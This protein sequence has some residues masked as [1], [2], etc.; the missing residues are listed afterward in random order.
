MAVDTIAPAMVSAFTRRAVLQTGIAMAPLSGAM[1]LGSDIIDLRGALPRNGTLEYRDPSKINAI[2]IHHTATKGQGWGTIAQFHAEARAWAA[3]GYTYGT[4]WDGRMFILGDI[5][6]RH[7]HT[8]G[9]NTSTV[10]LA[11]LGNFHHKYPSAAQTRATIDL[12]RRV[13]AM[14]GI[15]KIRAHRMYKST[16]CPGDSAMV[17]LSD[18]WY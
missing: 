14:Y 4:S 17:A 13:Q 12:A 15:P 18:L 8:A 3:I 10:G 11:M 1:G 16:A 9:A 6:R 7:I 2:V 5:D